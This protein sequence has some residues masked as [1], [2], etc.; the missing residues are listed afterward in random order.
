MTSNALVFKT[1]TMQNFLSFR[2]EVSINLEGNFVTVI[3]GE[4]RDTG[5]EDSR[6][7]VGKSAILDALCYV[8]FGKV[9][10]QISNKGLVNKHAP[11]GSSMAVTLEFFKGD[12]H[13]RIERG[14]SPSKLLFLSKPID[15]KDH[16]KSKV[17]RKFKY[18]QT[19]AS[20]K[21]T[22]DEICAILGYDLTL[23]EYLIANSSESTE[24]L[25][26]EEE[27]RRSVIE[28]LLGFSIMS[29]KAK[30][31]KEQRKEHSKELVSKESSYEATRQANKRIQGQVDD[32][33]AKSNSWEHNK[34]KEI[35][36]LTET[37]SIIKKA[38]AESE[39]ELMNLIR[40][41]SEEIKDKTSSLRENNS[42]LSAITKELNTERKD[43]KKLDNRLFEI[44]TVLEKL[45][46]S[47]CPTCKQHWEPE[48]EYREGIEKEQE[49]LKETKEELIRSINKMEQE[50]NELEP[51]IS[52]LEK[53][54]SELNSALKEARSEP[55]VY[56]S[57]EEA[58]SAGERLKGL[59]TQL[60][61]KQN[62]KN[63][64]T[65]SID[66]MKSKA[67][68][69]VDNKE[70]DELRS[71]ID[72]YNYI[73][74]LLTNRDSFLRKM[75]IERWLPKLNQRIAYWLEILDLPHVV[76]FHSDLSV[77]IM[78]FQEEF[79]LGNLSKGERNRLRMAT[80][81]AFQ[82]IF[83]HA[84]YR[85]SLLNIDELIDN[86]ICPRGASNAVS[87]IKEICHKKNKRIFLITHRDD[88][89]GRVEDVMKIIKENR[90]SRIE[91]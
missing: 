9:I 57:I 50:S 29:E 40:E 83:E 17:N 27:K 69:K 76:E 52:Q 38:D 53:E 31:L 20:K 79:D 58:A 1:L 56:S 2:K 12:Q 82:D 28:K 24:F 36:E 6:N 60:I 18:D 25:R 55:L 33:I 11:R 81:M 54:I 16:I 41:V 59:K 32:L 15:D 64:Y 86:G 42:G 70:L 35:S 85:I 65:E 77:T 37:I 72:H 43:L 87:A 73:I 5:G 3:L 10:R 8:L 49:S 51:I 91:Y 84:N 90:I 47:C 67:L 14:E 26:L 88:I 39:I 19:R 44:K 66:N 74:D 13:Y 68:K 48:P 7:A 46:E 63:P 62:Q 78:D 34:D 80:N 89:A 22:N 75:L 71:L 45:D 61:E 30:V 23:F 21:E 4:N